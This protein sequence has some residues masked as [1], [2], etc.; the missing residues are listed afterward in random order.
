MWPLGAGGGAAEGAGVSAA[1]DPLSVPVPGAH[2]RLDSAAAWAAAVAVVDDPSRAADA[3]AT[4][5]GTGRR[6]QARGEAAGVAVVEYYA[7]HPT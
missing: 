7:H 5:A 3:V 2:M 4:F 1:A 6:Y